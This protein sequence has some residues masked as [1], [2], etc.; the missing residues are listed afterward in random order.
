MIIGVFGLCGE[1]ANLNAHDCNSGYKVV[2]MT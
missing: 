2:N 1:C